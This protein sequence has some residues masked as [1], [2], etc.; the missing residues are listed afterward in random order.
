MHQYS[1]FYFQPKIERRVPIACSTPI[2]ITPC[3]VGHAPV[4]P[5]ASFYEPDESSNV[6]PKNSLQEMN[7]FLH[8][9]DVSP[10]RS[11]CCTSWSDTS[12]RTK[13]YYGRKA[14]EAVAAVMEEFAPNDAGVL[15]NYISDAMNKQYSGTGESAEKNVDVFFMATLAEYYRTA[16]GWE[17]RRQILSIM[18]E[19]L[20][21]AQIRKSIPDLSQ[22][23]FTEAKCHGLV[24]G[25]GQPI[26]SLSPRIRTVLS[27]DKIEH[28]VSFSPQ[29]IQ[30]L[31]F[32]EKTIKL[33]TNDQ[34]EQP[35]LVRMIIPKRI[36]QQYQAYCQ[37]S[38]FQALSRGV[39]L[40]ILEIPSRARLF[41]CRWCSGV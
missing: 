34:I 40:Q 16:C 39:L 27:T 4:T 26:Q 25:R 18:A 32:G 6:T 13:R 20:S 14:R 35:N 15:W 19:K 9:R 17:V 5:G 31:P 29:I 30:E 37:E 23:C 8:S 12:D 38:G 1:V 7:S 28:F 21:L 11:Q 36:I 2:M 33:S 41:Q 3:A 24:Y 10:V 22:W